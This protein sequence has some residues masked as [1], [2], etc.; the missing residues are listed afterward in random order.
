MPEVKFSSFS[1]YFSDF[2]PHMC[3]YGFNGTGKT[4]LAGKTGLR[5]VLL[6]CG[7][8]GVMTLRRTNNVKIIRI[9]S[10]LH[11]LDALGEAIAKADQIELLVPDTLTGL[12]SMA[13]KEVKPKRTFEMNQKKWG[14]AASRVIECISETSNFPNDVIYLAQERRRSRADEDSTVQIIS[15]S[16]TPSIREFLSSRVDW[17]GRLYLEDGK[18]KLDFVL[19]DTLEAKDRANLFPKIIGNLPEQGSYIPIRKRILEAIHS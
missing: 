17:V 8:A 5:T 19:S 4:T 2:H 13:I 14:S 15:P 18:R 10:I 11:Y 7:D 1:D 9:R 12:Q 6:D 3:I 16:L